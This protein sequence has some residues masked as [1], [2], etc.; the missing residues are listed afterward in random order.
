MTLKFSELW[1]RMADYPSVL[2]YRLI[3]K[4]ESGTL[5]FIEHL[6][7]FAEEHKNDDVTDILLYPHNGG[8]GLTVYLRGDEN[9]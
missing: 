9:G 4:D 1:T 3:D 8:V 2:K 6:D 7:K 5:T